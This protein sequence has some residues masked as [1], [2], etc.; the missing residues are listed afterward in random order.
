MDAITPANT[1][2]TTT[3]M[4]S[5]VEH[6]DLPDV[7]KTRA[8]HAMKHSKLTVA[9]IIIGIIIGVFIGPL[10]LILTAVALGRAWKHDDLLRLFA[11]VGVIISIVST[12]VIGWMLLPTVLNLIQQHG[13]LGELL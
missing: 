7:R 6:H 12:A 3:G 4:G 1:T 13:G 11:T 2:T 10:G 9:L 5:F 8:Q